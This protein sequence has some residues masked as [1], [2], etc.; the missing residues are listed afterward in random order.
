[1]AKL[2]FCGLGQMGAPMA[3]RLLAAGHELTIWNRTRPKAEWFTGEGAAIAGSP[4][5]A[6]ATS[7]AVITMLSTPQAL[8]EVTF[9]D[10]GLVRGLRPGATLIEMSTVGPQ[11]ITD[12][13]LGLPEEVEVLD[14]PVLGSVPQASQGSLKIFVGGPE[15][16]FATW[17]EV[18]GVLGTPTYMGPRG[19]G[20]AMK[21]VANCALGSLMAALGECLSLAQGLQLDE[22]VVFDVLVESP[23]GITASSKRDLIQSG[24]YPP[25]FKLSL[26]YKDLRLVTDEA[27]RRG[28]DLKLARNAAAWFQSAL[29][30]GL[31][32]LDYSAVVAAILGRRASP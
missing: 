7:D 29:E 1:M 19:S 27:E 6:A 31:S 21:L 25:N 4:G 26:A 23:I 3:R 12:L 24:H 28:L 18:L 17:R 2:A 16:R 5:E 13:A 11:A 9:S 32:D 22:K 8:N 30:R 14:A 10:D 20:A 15:A